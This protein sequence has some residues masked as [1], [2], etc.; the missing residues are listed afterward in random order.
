M[1]EIPKNA[2]PLLEKWNGGNAQLWGYVVSF[3]VLALRLEKE[4]TRGNIHIIC[5]SC[6]SLR[7]PLLFWQN[8]NIE[9]EIVE[10]DEA[11]GATF[12][13][14]DKAVGVVIEC[15]GIDFKENVEPVYGGSSSKRE[16]Q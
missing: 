6:R 3:R 1:K 10:Y 2:A 15:M 7:L 8:C 4:G 14:Q 16:E 11:L 12:H 9:I 5:R 13:V